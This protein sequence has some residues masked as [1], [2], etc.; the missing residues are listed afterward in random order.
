MSS[1]LSTS[2][3]NAII[4]YLDANV[5]ENFMNDFL[6]TL[7]NDARYGGDLHVLTY[8]MPEVFQNNIKNVKPNQIFIHP[9]KKT[10]PVFNQR[11]FDIEK[12]LGELSSSHVM[13]IDAGDVWFQQPFSEVFTL[14]DSKIGFAEENYTAAENWMGQCIRRLDK[15]KEIEAFELLDGRPTRCSG[16]ICGP[17]A[18]LRNFYHFMGER[19]RW[20]TQDFFGVDML[21]CNLA[22]R[23]AELSGIELRELER[24]YSFVT[25]PTSHKVYIGHKDCL[26]YDGEKHLVKVVHNAGGENGAFRIFKKGRPSVKTKLAAALEQPAPSGFIELA[27][28]VVKQ[29]KVSI[30]IPTAPNERSRRYTAMCIEAIKMHTDPEDT[31]YEIFTEEEGTSVHAANVLLKKA[32]SEY[33][34]YLSNDAFVTRG[35]LWSLHQ[36][37][38]MLE[39]SGQ[40]IGQLSTY[41]TGS[42]GN[43]QDLT[44]NQYNAVRIWPCPR[45]VWV[46][47][48]M[49]KKDFELIGGMDERFYGSYSDDDVSVRFLRSG[50]RNFTCPLIVLHVGRVGFDGSNEKFVEDMRRGEEI[51]SE[52]WGVN[53]RENY[54]IGESL[55]EKKVIV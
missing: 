19:M 16:M 14:C 17:K 11:V 39:K 44:S 15:E 29:P 40:K 22:A 5:I 18:E 48:M 13:T 36:S 50:Y 12:L 30:L 4:T 37:W 34:V 10:G 31:P 8:D 32:T 49:K 25:L 26:F 27:Q 45:I 55:A 53:W 1:E 54:K 42:P 24:T 41:F 23:D 6:P 38:E 2:S 9:V 20:V 21:A 43:I 7:F 33:V 35:W 28:V 51:I 3:A 46:C 52:K 47:V